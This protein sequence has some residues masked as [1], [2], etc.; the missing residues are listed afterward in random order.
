MQTKSI[1]SH[2]EIEDRIY[3]EIVVDAYGEEERAMGWYYYLQNT[4]TFPFKACCIV[5]KGTSP[6]VLKEIVKVIDLAKEEECVHDMFVKVKW[7]NRE[8]S[9]PLS[10]LEAAQ[11]IDDQTHQALGD[12]SYWLDQG[13]C[14]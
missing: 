12:W 10:Q 11:E 4:L 7:N 5:E 14:F 2:Q 1:D 13:H 8:F 3:M 6:L 9:V